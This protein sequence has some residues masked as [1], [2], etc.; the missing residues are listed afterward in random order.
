MAL[1]LPVAS[2]VPLGRKGTCRLKCIGLRILIA[3]SEEAS[4]TEGACRDVHHDEAVPQLADHLQSRA[5]TLL[6]EYLDECVP[7]T[8]QM[9]L[10]TIAGAKLMDGQASTIGSATLV[11]LH[12]QIVPT[13]SCVSALLAGLP[14]VSRHRA[15]PRGRV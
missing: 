14:A 10:A 9:Q 7:R 6:T 1:S 8:T 12:F 13:S 11:I 3:L 2:H 5:F 4:L 15:L